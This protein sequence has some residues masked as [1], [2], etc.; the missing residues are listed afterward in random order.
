MDW[1]DFSGKKIGLAGAGRENLSLIPHLIQAGATIVL[2]EQWESELPSN[3]QGKIKAVIGPDHLSALV[4]CDYIF[5]SPGLPLERLKQAVGDKPQLTSAVDLLLALRGRQTIAVTGTKGKGTTATMITAILKAA[6]RDVILAGNI[7]NSIYDDW[8]KITDQTVIVMELSSFQLEDI[9]H[10][11]HIAVVLP[12]T[13]DH[14]QPLSE[15]SPNFH[16]D[17]LSYI[18]AKQQITAHQGPDDLV[19]YSLDSQASTQIGQSSSAQKVGVSIKTKADV[20]AG[21]GVLRVGQDEV[22]LSKETKLRGDHLF[23]NAAMAAAVGQAEGVAVGKI[24]EGLGNYRPLP[25]R[26]ETVGKFNG[27]EFVDDSYATAPD[28]TIAALSAF[29]D[30]PVV[31]I[32]GGSSKGADFSELA[33]AAAGIKVAVLIGQEAN[34]IAAAFKKY[35]PGV[36]LITGVN[37]FKDAVETAVHR[38]IPGDVVLLSPACA[39]KDMFKDAAERG[40]K[41]VK[42]VHELV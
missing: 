8:Q 4:D 19:V 29:T 33:K 7:G 31:I 30:Q 37:R 9:T 39:S 1:S 14:L 36:T 42:F 34:N 20:F 12:I 11:P 17:L 2:G 40:E 13:A 35:A 27:I 23:H 28:A 24:I 32:L 16:R 3:I 25:H 21:G 22:D 5:R 26:M 15:R 38:A 18:A 6:G 41:F 10:A